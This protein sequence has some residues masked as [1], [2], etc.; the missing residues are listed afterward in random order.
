[1]DMPLSLN[2]RFFGIAP[3]AEEAFDG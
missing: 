1:M 3:L 2:R